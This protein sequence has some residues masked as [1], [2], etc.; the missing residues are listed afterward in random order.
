MAFDIRVDKADPIARPLFPPA[1]TITPCLCVRD[2]LSPGHAK[3]HCIK[4]FLIKWPDQEVS[5][6]ITHLQE[7]R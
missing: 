6:Y 5:D 1:H 7:G 3:N 4:R 2:R